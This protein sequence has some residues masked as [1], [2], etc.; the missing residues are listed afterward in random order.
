[1]GRDYKVNYLLLVFLLRYL[2]QKQ[3][4]YDTLIILWL[5]IHCLYGKKWTLLFYMWGK[6]QLFVYFWVS[7]V[8]QK[9][10]EK[11]I[12]LTNFYCYSGFY[13]TLIEWLWGDTYQR[14]KVVHIQLV[15][16]V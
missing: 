9:F 12:I 5:T 14:L 15:S 10:T 16:K 2:S 11:I 6:Y 1:M 13:K 7:N 4:N 8:F 3:T